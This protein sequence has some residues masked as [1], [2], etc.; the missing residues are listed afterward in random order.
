MNLGVI[1]AQLLPAV[2]QAVGAQ[3]R[4][5]AGPPVTSAVTGMRVDVWVHAARFEDFPGTSSRG[6]G[7]ARRPVQFR[8]DLRGFVE[9]RPG[10]IVIDITCTGPTYAS[11]QKVCGALPP[12]VLLALETM[13]HPELSSLPDGSV[14]LRFADFG[15]VVGTTS[16]SHRVSGDAAYFEGLVTFQLEGFLHVT[17]TRGGGLARAT[18]IAPAAGLALLVVQGPVGA[19]VTGEHVVI[20]NNTEE[21]VS[22]GGFVLQ[23]AAPTRPH[24]FVLPAATV[25][26]GGSLTIWTGRGQ[27]DAENIFW[28]RAKSVW[29][30]PGDT[31]SLLDT[32]GLRV[33][34]AR[35]P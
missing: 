17:V 7:T 21:A 3:V 34:S 5:Q 1:E 27:N 6:P 29:N 20:T 14:L 8:Q 28:G 10:R 32:A 25:P 24:R 9:E 16:V 22:L 19:D 4:T 23:D 18:A 11:V 35:Y 2:Q 26:P 13:P 33:A 31:V 30:T 12:P 15:A